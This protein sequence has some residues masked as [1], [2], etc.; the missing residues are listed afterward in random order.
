MSQGQNTYPNTQTRTRTQNIHEQ[1]F[2][3]ALATVSA[4]QFYTEGVFCLSPLDGTTVITKDMLMEK[5]P[6]DV[7]KKITTGISELCPQ[8]NAITNPLTIVY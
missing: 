7:A 8:K 1:A 5:I 3:A 6:A 2:G 4:E